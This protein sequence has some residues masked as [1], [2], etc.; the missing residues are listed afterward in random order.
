MEGVLSHL[1]WC[2]FVLLG[3]DGA[4]WPT[5]LGTSGDATD[6]SYPLPEEWA[7]QDVKVAWEVSVGP[8]F[9]GA[10]IRDGQVY[11][12]D[13]V[14]EEKDVLRCL[15][16]GSGT[17]QWS[18][19][20][21]ARG[22]LSYPGSRMVP[23]VEEELVYTLGGFGHLTCV[24]RG[25]HEPQWAVDLREE[26]A[27]DPPRWGW[28]QSPLVIQDLLVVAVLSESVGLWAVDR[29][30]GEE[31]WRT[32][33]I[34][35]THSTP[36]LLE[37][38]GVPQILI[39]TTQG[40]EGLLSSFAPEEGRLLWRSTA[41]RCSYPIPPP[42]KIDEQRLFLTGGYR[43]GSLMLS[44]KREAA[45]YQVE[46]LFRVKRGSQIHVPVRHEDH[47]YFLANENAT[48]KKRDRSKGG[49]MC[50]SLDGKEQW[51]TADQ[52]YF[53]RGSV[54]LVDGVLLTQ[55]GD[56]GTLRLVE[57]SPDG[58]RLLGE[59]PVFGSLGGDHQ[60]WAPL[61]FCKGRLIMRSQDQMKCVVLVDDAG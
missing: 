27:T 25:T 34:G 41:Y 7:A 3:G 61:A 21:P 50:L 30:T 49:L 46:E 19:E 44:V 26:F 15:D 31:V 38:D 2:C 9:G 37:L 1:W 35:T 8:G 52:P 4:E 6:H 47:L 28:S 48:D 33:G 18:F 13:R 58:Y 5:F 43:A 22:R 57:A 60:M 55:D 17:Q 56:N 20:Y 23:T 14:A 29:F 36:V 40:E 59:R 39:L 10:A 53:G 16:L 45:E 54:L 42:I 11:F 24:D 32:E 51:R 12:L